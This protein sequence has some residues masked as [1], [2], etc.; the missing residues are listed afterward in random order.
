MPTPREILNAAFERATASL[1]QS[2]VTH[3]EVERRIELVCRNLSNR[4]LARLLLSCSL[5]KIY[6]PDVDIRKPYTQIGE[7]SFSGRSYDEG[8]ISTFI[9]DH[10]L[11]CNQTTAFLTPALRNRNATLTPESNLVGR[12]PALYQAVLQL[13][14]DVYTAVIS[15]EDLLTETLRWLLIVKAEK[16]Q[17]METMLAALRTT[18]GAVPLSAEAIV[19][20]VD[21]HLKVKGASRLPVLVVAAAYASAGDRIGERALPLESHNAADKQTGTVGDVEVTLIG[22]DDIVTGYEMKLRRVTRED[23]DIALHKIIDKGIQNYIFITTD[24]IDIE[25]KEYA[26]SLYES[27]GGI[28][29]VVLDCISFLR[30]FLHLFH[31]L[32]AEY[33]KAYQAFV[34]A[35]PDSSVSQP[36]KEAWL[37]L[38]QAAESGSGY[39][40]ETELE[41]D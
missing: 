38:R 1:E 19:T 37:A 36:V 23:V 17:R 33:V 31:R 26:A 25:V 10:G 2:T 3:R 4:A 21:Q 24:A 32:R 22:D 7:G 30:H 16:Q 34:L 13:L 40:A 12:P 6:N 14:T 11:P 41:A 29:V 18:E 35:Q 27:T 15:A 20:L 28:E 9:I 5:A 8:Y 39:S